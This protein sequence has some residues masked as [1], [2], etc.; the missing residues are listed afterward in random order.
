LPDLTLITELAKTAQMISIYSMGICGEER[1]KVPALK[2]VRLWRGKAEG[3]QVKKSRYA[4][5]MGSQNLSL[6]FKELCHWVAER[7]ARKWPEASLDSVNGKMTQLPS[8]E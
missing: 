8:T 5:D 7:F 1:F 3:H 2:E 6:F 4:L